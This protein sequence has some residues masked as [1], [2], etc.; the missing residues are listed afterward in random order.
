MLLPAEQQQSPPPPSPPHSQ[1]TRERWEARMMRERAS[2]KSEVSV[3]AANLRRQLQHETGQEN[4]M[5]R[6]DKRT[7]ADAKLL[8]QLS[9]V[10]KQKQESGEP[11]ETASKAWR[12]RCGKCE[13]CMQAE[14]GKCGNCLDK[15][16]FGGPGARKQACSA[17]QCL[18]AKP[19]YREVRALALAP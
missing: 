16:K 3:V 1:M 13:L 10:P 19:G 8:L 4:L 11:R 18:F 12:L 2:R 15:R 7:I 17:R 6:V 9:K 14:C 5:Q